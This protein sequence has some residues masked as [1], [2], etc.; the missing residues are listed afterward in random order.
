MFYNVESYFQKNQQ[1][2]LVEK[3]NN[4][5]NEEMP[6]PHIHNFFEIYYLMN[7]NSNYTIGDEL[8]H[9]EPKNIILIP[10]GVPHKSSTITN[11][12][13]IN[14]YFSKMYFLNK[15]NAVFT[16]C[17]DKH[18]YTIPYEL[19]SQFDV[20]FKSLLKET[21]QP[22]SDSELITRNYMSILLML[23][24]R[25]RNREEINNTSTD[26]IIKESLVYI[27]E[28]LSENLSLEH[29]AQYVA[30]NPSYFSRKF[31]SVVGT[32][33]KNYIIFTRVGKAQQLLSSSELSLSEISNVCGFQDSNYF[34]TVFKKIVGV[35]PAKFRKQNKI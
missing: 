13:R 32:N 28:H 26:A 27:S 23:L 17:F 21:S 34:S 12:S 18:F 4:T 33:F 22:R 9:L 10:P 14:I 20:I 16:K 30:L 24:N 7:G 29:V 3:I 6:A 2:I 31:K 15:E 35:S 19:T 25:L 11:L 1:G 5:A 8:F